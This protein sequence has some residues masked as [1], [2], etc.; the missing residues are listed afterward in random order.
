MQIHAELDDFTSSV[1]YNCRPPLDTSKHDIT[2]CPP[3]VTEHHS[4]CW[5]SPVRCCLSRLLRC[6][7]CHCTLSPSGSPKVEIWRS[8]MWQSRKLQVPW[9]DSVSQWSN[10][11]CR[12][13]ECHSLKYV[14][15]VESYSCTEPAW[16]SN[17]CEASLIIQELWVKMIQALYMHH[18][19]KWKRQSDNNHSNPTE[20]GVKICV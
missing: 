8:Q 3:F 1:K 15:N 18:P 2:C 11:S 20:G 19:T 6:M 12:E 5:W 7:V 13:N 16:T 14:Q 9:N 17:A 10:D 4:Q